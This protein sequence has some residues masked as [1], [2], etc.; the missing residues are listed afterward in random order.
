MYQQ[1]LQIF[2]S[3]QIYQIQKVLKMCDQLL[4]TYIFLES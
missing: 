4:K 1:Q 3:N 2:I